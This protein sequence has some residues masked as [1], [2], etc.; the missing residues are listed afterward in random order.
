MLLQS[1]CVIIIIVVGLIAKLGFE[2]FCLVGTE[3]TILKQSTL[4]ANEFLEST[5][6]KLVVDFSK[7]IGNSTSLLNACFFKECQFYH[8]Y[9]MAGKMSYVSQINLMKLH[10]WLCGVN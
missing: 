1:I 7:F 6:N 5:N 4:K 3:E 2:G 9:D 8:Y 10:A